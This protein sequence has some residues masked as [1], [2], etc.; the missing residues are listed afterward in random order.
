MKILLT[1]AGLDI[2]GAETHV[3][4]L[5]TELHSRG[6][7]VIIASGG[8]VYADELEAIG[9]KHYTVPLTRRNIG[10]MIKSRRMLK[11]IIH[12]EKP[13]IVHAHARI[14]AFII[15][16]LRKSCNFVFVTTVHGAFDTSFL[17]RH[18]SGWGNKT[19]AVSE[20]LKKYL[21][22]NYDVDEKDVY[23]SINGISTVK[24]NKN[25]DGSKIGAEF[26]FSDTKNRICYVSRL[27]DGICSCAYMLI[28][29]MEKICNSVPDAELIIVGGGEHYDALYKKS[30]ELNNRLGRRAII[31]TGGRTDVN[32]IHAAS[33]VCVGVSRAILEPMAMER[34]CIVA[35]DPGY[36]GIMDESKLP[37]ATA[38]NFT[39]RGCEKVNAE[40]M[41]DDIISLLTMDEDKAD[42]LREFAG[43]V[44][45]ENYSIDRMVSD[46]EKMYVDAMKEYGCDAA[47][48]GYYG[49]GNC[50]DDALLHAILK[51]M[52]EARPYFSPT[53]L[54]Y[55]PAKTTDDY[56]VKAINRFDIFAVRRLFNKTKLFIAGGGS[57]IQDITS[58]KSLIYYLHL[59][60]LAKKKG[61]PV[62]LY[63]NGIGPINKKSNRKSAAK[64]LNQADVITLRDWESL[65]LLKEM[66]VTK[67]MIK[68]T[69][70]PAISLECNKDVNATEI[71]RKYGLG[72]EEK[73][74]CV[75]LRRWKSMG[76]CADAFADICTEISQKYGLVPVL[77]PMQYSKDIAISREIAEKTDCRCVLIDEPLTADEIMNILAMSEGAI[78]VRLHMLIFGVTVGIPVL[79][80]DYDPKVSSFQKFAGLE[81]CITMADISDG[82]YRLIADDFFGKR[83]E[84]AHSVETKLPQF[85]DAAKENAR[86][87]VELINHER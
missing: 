3:A 44:V 11:K 18:L 59:I 57:L 22:E 52:Y 4:E 50:G 77:V 83:H 14:P 81:H 84:I 55:K 43:K 62:M 10:D 9:I 42:K 27:E 75:S 2:G 37:M 5:A 29:K 32:E 47:I 6:H 56:G 16:T 38:T 72:D 64:I 58:T 78:T 20:D 45:R 15:D 26:G 34:L 30:E 25:I 35:G 79:G 63:G 51:D 19:L 80:I 61:I 54:S 69:A 48:L 65:E 70:D 46:N 41:A 1:L 28:D 87:A 85:K 7:K 49:Y 73:Y 23:T 33:K 31:M 67:P 74:F 17:L 86:I 68:V 36:I 21:L 8:G 82:K 60:R 71:L 66:G 24:F 12:K 40:T 39:C 53:V 13:D 76:N